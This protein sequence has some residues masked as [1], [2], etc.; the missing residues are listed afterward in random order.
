MIFIYCYITLLSGEALNNFL[1]S[2]KD[3][4]SSAI[5]SQGQAVTAL[6]WVTKAL[7]LR[8]HPLA[9]KFVEMVS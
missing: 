8:G 6:S 4:L 3:K 1:T 5:T 2:L 7:V 9:G